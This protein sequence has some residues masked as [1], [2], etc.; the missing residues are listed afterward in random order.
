MRLPL[1]HL[2]LAAWLVLALAASAE[3]A[4]QVAVQLE[5]RDALTGTDLDVSIRRKVAVGTDA[6]S[7]I[8]DAVDMEYRRYPGVGVFVTSL[9]GVAAPKG[10][11]WAL[12]INGERATKGISE[13]TIKEPVRIRWDLVELGGNEP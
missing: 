11:F 8:D 3:D 13:L 4:P 10:A 6:V 9:C 12:S 5:I 2:V 7:F 1:R